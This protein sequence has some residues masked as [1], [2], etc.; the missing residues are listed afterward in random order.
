MQ[1]SCGYKSISD[2]GIVTKNIF[3]NKIA[4]NI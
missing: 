3:L 4:K 2:I 1:G